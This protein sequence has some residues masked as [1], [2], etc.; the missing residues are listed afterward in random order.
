[1]T[2][3]RINQVAIFPRR[4]AAA[5]W[6]TGCPPR[7]NAASASPRESVANQVLLWW[8]S[9]H[10]TGRRRTRT[11]EIQG[12]VQ[13]CR[14][15]GP[16]HG[17]H[18]ALSLGQPPPL[19]ADNPGGVGSRTLLRARPP[20]T[21]S[22]RASRAQRGRTPVWPVARARPLAARAG[23]QARTTSPHVTA[24]NATSAGNRTNP[25]STAA[26]RRHGGELRG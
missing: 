5:T 21:P 13:G 8:D 26:C 11:P 17:S 23:R 19:A 18:A 25:P 12:A 10:P 9:W 20:H 14:Q 15:R 2:T 22:L 4:A 6:A 16:T 7:L 1:M 3:G 24:D